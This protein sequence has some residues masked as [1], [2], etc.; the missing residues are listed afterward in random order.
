MDICALRHTICIYISHITMI[1]GTTMLALQKTSFVTPLRVAS[2]GTER[3]LSMMGKQSYQV[4]VRVL[5][6]AH[7]GFNALL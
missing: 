1:G 6:K 4:D 7:Y 5:F 2:N 3:R